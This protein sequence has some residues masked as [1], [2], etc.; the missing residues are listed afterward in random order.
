MVAK[1]N[2]AY[3]VTLPSDREI[4]MTRVFNAPRE[5]VFKAHVDP[6]LIAQ[7]WGLRS[8]TTIVDQMDARP[9]GK[10]RLVQ[11]RP[12]GSEEG[13][14]GEFREIVPPERFTWTFEWEGMPGHV[15]LETYTF[16][17]HAGKTTLTATSVFN[18]LEERDGVI[19]SGME[20][21]ANE[22]ADRLE[23]LLASL[24]A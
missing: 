21:G 14:R 13:F 16:E 4:V 15:G 1:S 24:Q 3:K 5:L 10:W 2:S 17:E 22:S 19:A 7:W 20:A 18:T 6:T 9:G 8:N 23:E 11:R 12:D